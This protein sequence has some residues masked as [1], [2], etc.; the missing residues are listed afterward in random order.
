[1]PKRPGALPTTA[2][3]VTLALGGCGDDATTATDE[4]AEDT[5]SSTNPVPGAD[6]PAA[7]AAVTALATQL[8]LGEGEVVVRRVE[9]VTWRDGSLGC[10][11]KGVMYTQAL[12]E[13]HR[14]VLEAA[15]REY[16]LHDGAGREPFLCEDPT[17]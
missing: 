4:P 3:L 9:E 7:R 14:V 13:G 10:A 12:V 2:L 15:G 1:M 16:E 6:S 11:E 5:M 8:G 17:E